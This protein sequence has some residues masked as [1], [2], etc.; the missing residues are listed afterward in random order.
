MIE[1][2]TCNTLIHIYCQTSLLQEAKPSCGSI[3]L[4][5]CFLPSSF[6]I[7]GAAIQAS[8]SFLHLR[9]ALRRILPYFL[10]VCKLLFFRMQSHPPVLLFLPSSF[11]SLLPPAYG[12]SFRLLLCPVVVQLVMHK[13]PRGIQFGQLSFRTRS[14]HPSFCTS[15]R[16]RDI[17]PQTIRDAANRR[18]WNWTRVGQK[19][20]A[21]SVSLLKGHHIVRSPMGFL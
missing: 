12:P 20:K 2:C 4:L 6:L 17:E 19:G 10:N 15:Q 18:M 3:L 8:I 11:L 21:S 1:S 16:N 13:Y 14:A 5:R 7:P 9:I